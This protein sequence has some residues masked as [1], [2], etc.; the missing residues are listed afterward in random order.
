MSEILTIIET[1]GLS[2]ALVIYLLWEKHNQ[3]NEQIKTMSELT[4]S[5]IKLADAIENLSK[6]VSGNES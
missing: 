5:N 4:S 1:Q 2:I 3:G 6:K